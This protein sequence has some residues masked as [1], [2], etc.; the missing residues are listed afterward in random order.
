MRVAV[1]RTVFFLIKAVYFQKLLIE[2]LQKMSSQETFDV[3]YY[4]RNFTFTVCQRKRIRM[5]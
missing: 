2:I 3:S 5:I 1:R 4:Y